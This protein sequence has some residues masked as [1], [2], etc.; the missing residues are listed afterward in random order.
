MAAIDSIQ[1]AVIETDMDIDMVYNQYVH[2]W[3]AILS[4]SE[5]ERVWEAALTMIPELN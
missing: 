1:R 3:S 5:L 2:D 4:P